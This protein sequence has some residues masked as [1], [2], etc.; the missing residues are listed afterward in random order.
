MSKIRGLV[1]LMLL[2]GAFGL[3][4]GCAEDGMDGTDG[5][6]GIS[7]SN[8]VDGTDGTDGNDGNDGNDGGSTTVG[9]TFHVGD[10]LVEDITLNITAA[11]AGATSTINFEVRDDMGRGGIGVVTGSGGDVRLP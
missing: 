11:A 4:A 1:F 7:G 2:V 9:E 3:V 6:A 5:D 10:T 8:G